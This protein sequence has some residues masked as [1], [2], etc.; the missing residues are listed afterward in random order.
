MTIHLF[1]L[2]LFVG[3]SHNSLENLPFMLVL[4]LI[5]VNEP[6]QVGFYINNSCT[7]MKYTWSVI[8]YFIHCIYLLQKLEILLSQVSNG[9]VKYT[10]QSVNLVCGKEGA[11]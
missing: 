1:Q 2:F 3:C 9:S 7:C 11:F 6:K 4:S 8:Y 5:V 10:L